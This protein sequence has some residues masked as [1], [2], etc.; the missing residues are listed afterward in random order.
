MNEPNEPFALPPF[1]SLFTESAPSDDAL[2]RMLDIAVDPATPDPGADL[3]PDPDSL[4]TADDSSEDIE[5]ADFD[6]LSLDDGSPADLADLDADLPETD[7]VDFG[8]GYSDDDAYGGDGLD[9]FE[10]DSGAVDDF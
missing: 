6:E 3:I 10:F 2:M 4:F 8:G 1:S 7:P 9:S 5:L